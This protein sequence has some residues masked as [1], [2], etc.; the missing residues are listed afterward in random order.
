MDID[1]TPPE[2]R[3]TT[4]DSGTAPAGAPVPFE[5]FQPPVT[6]IVTIPPEHRQALLERAAA[7]DQ[8]VQ[9]WATETLVAVLA[10]G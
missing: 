10:Q 6:L 9:A 2:A 7:A 1:T 8:T 4:E 5:I 3:E